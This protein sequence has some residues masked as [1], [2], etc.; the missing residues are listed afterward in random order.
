MN[1][2]DQHILDA[3]EIEAA[4]TPGGGW[5]RD[6]RELGRPLAPAQRMAA[7]IA[8]AAPHASAYDT[9]KSEWEGA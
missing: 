7:S 2:N 3:A 1:N 4:R 5:S 8:R 9:L 6:P